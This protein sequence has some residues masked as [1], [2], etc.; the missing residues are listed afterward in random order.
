MHSLELSYLIFPSLVHEISSNF[1][2]QMAQVTYVSAELR[3]VLTKSL[4]LSSPNLVARILN[5]LKCT[6]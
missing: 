3:Y 1:D 6:Q 5:G 4:F 2:V